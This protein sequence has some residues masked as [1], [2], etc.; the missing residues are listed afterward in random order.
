MFLLDSFCLDSEFLKFSLSQSFTK[1]KF[2][3]IILITC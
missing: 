3:F 2:I 1:Q